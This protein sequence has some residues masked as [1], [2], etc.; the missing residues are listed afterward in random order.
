MRTTRLRRNHVLRCN[1]CQVPEYITPRITLHRFP[2][3]SPKSI[4]HKPSPNEDSESGSRNTAEP[5]AISR[6]RLC[7]PLR[8]GLTTQCPPG[9]ST[10]VMPNLVD[11]LPNHRVAEPLIDRAHKFSP[12]AF[13]SQMTRGRLRR[14]RSALAAARPSLFAA[15]RPHLGRNVSHII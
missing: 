15:A 3:G 2:R 9:H 11:K 14:G 13:R 10:S 7:D 12:L 5:L 6:P 4:L 1:T 8:T